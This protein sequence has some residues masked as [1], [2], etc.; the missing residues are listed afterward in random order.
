MLLI[1]MTAMTIGRYLSQ[2]GLVHIDSQINTE[3]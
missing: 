3:I 1:M 2:V